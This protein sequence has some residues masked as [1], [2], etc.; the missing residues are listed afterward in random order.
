[1]VCETSREYAQVIGE[2][3]TFSEELYNI[4]LGRIGNRHDAEDLLQETYLKFYK[5][6]QRGN[7][8][9]ENALKYLSKMAVNAS[10]TFLRK[11]SPQSLYESPT[12]L[13]YDKD[14]RESL[15][16]LQKKLEDSEFSVLIEILKSSTLEKEVISTADNLDSLEFL[17]VRSKLAQL[18]EFYDRNGKI[19]IPPREIASVRFNPFAIRFKPRR[20][21][22]SPIDYFKQHLEVYQG[23]SRSDLSKYDQGL[24]NALRHARQLEEA[25][26]SDMRSDRDHRLPLEEQ[27]KIVL[28]YKLFGASSRAT[29]K[30]LPYSPNTILRYWKMYNLETRKNNGL[31]DS[32]REKIVKAY[33]KHNGIVSHAAKSL[34]HSRSIVA[35]VWKEEDLEI[36]SD[37]GIKILTRM[38]GQHCLSSSESKKVINAFKICSGIISR[39]AKLTGHCE[40]TI[41]RYWKNKGLI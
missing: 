6:V 11:K 24:Y 39:A 17:E 34:G 5:R 10:R 36:R 13:D 19:V 25:I 16:F 3:L 32:E 30:V 20:F 31:L 1:M 41:K 33:K 9:P 37:R 26:P 18:A 21:N 15:E 8:Q 2:A 14:Y 28:A 7:F 35:E 23:L 12:S 29:A 27:R 4:I 40:K 22:G 38:S